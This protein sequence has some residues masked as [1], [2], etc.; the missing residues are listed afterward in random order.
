M[1]LQSV[2]LSQPAWSRL[3]SHIKNSDGAHVF[4]GVHKK[5]KDFE[6]WDFGE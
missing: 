4:I 6:V 5:R 3:A 2:R 1:I